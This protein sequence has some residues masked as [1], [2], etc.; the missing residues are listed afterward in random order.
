MPHRDL[1]DLKPESPSSHARDAANHGPTRS[2]RPADGRDGC[3]RPSAGA[4][5]RPRL[6]PRGQRADRARAADDRALGPGSDRRTRPDRPRDRRRP[7]HRQQAVAAHPARGR[8]L[9]ESAHAPPT[10]ELGHPALPRP[11]RSPRRA[12]RDHHPERRG[13][14]RERRGRGAPA[15]FAP[16]LLAHGGRGRQSPHLRRRLYGDV[17]LHR[18]GS[19]RRGRARPDPSRRPG[20]CRRGLAGRPV[21]QPRSADPSAAQAQGRELHVGRHDPAQLPQH[22]R[23]QP[24]ARRDHRH[25]GR[26]AGP[27]S[28]RGTRGAA[29]PAHQC[30]AGRAAAPRHR[31]QRALP[32]RPPAGHPLRLRHADVGGGQSRGAARRRT[33]LRGTSPRSP[34]RRRQ[35]C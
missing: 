5:R 19:D 2:S 32:Q 25:L 17:R 6:W 9:G 34:R 35:R 1:A 29:S 15:R 24:R 33:R 16:L 21:D 26:D 3:R 4:L 18:R 23:T 28:A 22:A 14:G 10:L 13:R 12:D 27:G 7:H 8:C 20:P 11:P 31:G 30:D